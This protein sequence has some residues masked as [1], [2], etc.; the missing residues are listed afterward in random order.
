[1][2]GHIESTRS[3]NYLPKQMK[4]HQSSTRW[5]AAELAARCVVERARE[6]LPTVA[7]M[8]LAIASTVVLV[9]GGCASSAGMATSAQPI[10]ADGWPARWP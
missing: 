8:A 1:M 7:A 9:L 10:A 5:A 4:P 3:L 6:S 2:E